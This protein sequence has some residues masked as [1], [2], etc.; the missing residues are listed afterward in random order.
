MRKMFGNWRQHDFVLKCNKINLFCKWKII[1][2]I[3]FKWKK[4]SNFLIHEDGLN[5]LLGK[6]RIE[7][8]TTQPYLVFFL[9]CLCYVKCH[10][11]FFHHAEIFCLLL[12]TQ[13]CISDASLAKVLLFNPSQL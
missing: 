8:G 5:L 12:L 1:S 3:F 6:A 7:L 9:C 10:T 2:I 4:T 11:L 13:Y